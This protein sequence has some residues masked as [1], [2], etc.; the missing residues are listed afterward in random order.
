MDLTAEVVGDGLDGERLAP[1][2]RCYNHQSTGT[3]E[4]NTCAYS[5]YV[6]Y[7]TGGRTNKS[8]PLLLHTTTDYV[9]SVVFTVVY[10]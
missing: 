4:G 7:E 9:Y 3:S 10:R 2:S 5:R 8:R 6:G 1:E